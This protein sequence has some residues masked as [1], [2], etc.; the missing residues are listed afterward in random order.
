M[1]HFKSFISIAMNAKGVLDLDTTKGCAHGLALDPRGCYGNCYAARMSAARGVDFSRTA[2]RHFRSRSELRAIQLEILRSP[3]LFVRIG[4]AGDPSEAWE[5]TAKV[6]NKIVPARK[7]IV[8]ITKH[9]IKASDEI[10]EYLVKAK[11][12][13]NT[14]TSPLDTP[15]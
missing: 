8:L 3:A 1:R 15:A 5:H 12:Y 2:I 9:W 13:L 14:S 7:P 6:I 11:V 4:T 10:L